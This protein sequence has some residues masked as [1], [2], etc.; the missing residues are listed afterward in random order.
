MQQSHC[1][2]QKI[3]Q[4]RMYFEN[5]F[6]NCFIVLHKIMRKKEASFAFG[7][8]GNGFGANGYN[9]RPIQEFGVNGKG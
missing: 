7:A 9:P 6:Q 8:N 5:Y 1:I 3:V 2:L 4:K